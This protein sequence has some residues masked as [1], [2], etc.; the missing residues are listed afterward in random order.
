MLVFFIHGVAT[1]T[2]EYSDSLQTLMKNEFHQRGQ[3]PPLFYSG[4]WANIYKEIENLWHRT[5]RELQKLPDPTSQFDH[6]A[7]RKGYF[8]KFA[9]D[10]FTYLNVERGRKIRQAIAGQL[11]DFINKNPRQ[12]DIHIIAHSL[13]SVILWDMLFSDNFSPEDAAQEFRACFRQPRTLKSVTTIGSPIAFFNLTAG[14][15]PQSVDRRVQNYSNPP[16]KWLNIVN[17]S[18]IIAHPILPAIDDGHHPLKNIE[19]KDVYATATLNLAQKTLQNTLDKITTAKILPVEIIQNFRAAIGSVNAHSEYWQSPQTA[20]MIV[21]HIS[22]APGQNTTEEIIEYLKR[23][24]EF[25][26]NMTSLSK[27]FGGEETIL[28]LKPKNSSVR[29]RMTKNRIGICHVYVLDNLD[30]SIFSGYVSWKN[31]TALD[32]AMKMIKKEWC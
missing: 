31:K 10:A 1:R 14:I 30:R 18:D 28:E 3:D 13:G 8:S 5:D 9:G 32:R 23:I 21:N 25:K 11:Q 7:F 26:I 15:Q 6:Q 4:L 29:L 12:S 17:S 24:P 2:T 16:L 19:I 20:R 27:N 22:D